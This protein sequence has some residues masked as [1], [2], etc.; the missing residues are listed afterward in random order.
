MTVANSALF[1]PYSGYILYDAVWS[2]TTPL[3]TYSLTQL[4]YLRPD[5]QIRFGVV[6]PTITATLAGGARL[7]DVV[8]IPMSNLDSGTSPTILRLTNSAGLDVTVEMAS[9][10]ADR[11]PLT[12]VLDLRGLASAGVRTSNVWNFIINNNSANVILG[13][14]LWL[15]TL[16]AFT[17]NFRPGITM[18]EVRHNGTQMNEYG[19]VN[20]VRART[21][22]RFAEFAVPSRYAQRDAFV[23]WARSGEG[24]GLPSLFWPLPTV[25]DCFFGSWTDTYASTYL[26]HN[27]S[28]MDNIR[29]EEWNK[30]LPV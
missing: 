8:A 5:W 16:S 29:F 7:A 30:G 20:R 18:G 11:I 13:S 4:A 9:L 14:A 2:G 6:N 25:N 27:Y 10:P 1:S 24:S 28:P 19:V 26:V 15:G 22:T 3:T 23:E 12:T 17:E 21:R